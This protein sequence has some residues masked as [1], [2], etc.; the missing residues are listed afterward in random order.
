MGQPVAINAR[1]RRTPDIR[2][3]ALRRRERKVGEQ[4]LAPVH[5]RA[6]AK[7]RQ[8][9]GGRGVEIVFRH[10]RESLPLAA[11]EASDVAAVLAEQAR[12]VIFRMALEKYEEAPAL[13]REAVDARTPRARQDV[14]TAQRELAFAQSVP[15]R[16]R[17]RD[18]GRDT[19][20][21][22]MIAD[23]VAVED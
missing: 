3:A 19:L 23:P 10:R 11:Q 12:R 7:R 5:A 14:V 1:R 8:Q 18:A 22:R 9:A 15:A 2:Q 13:L 6:G 16:M 4:L 20:H 17:D 21:Q